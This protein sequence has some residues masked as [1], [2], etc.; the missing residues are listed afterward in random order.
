VAEAKH[1]TDL[2]LQELA[3][4]ERVEAELDAFIEKRAH[5]AED[6]ENVA[7]LWLKTEREHHEK[8]RKQNAQDWFEY[9]D[10]IIRSQEATLGFLVAYHKQERARFAH[11][12]GLPHFGQGGD[13]A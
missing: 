1:I 2:S 8:H 7:N 5:Q 4:T 10:N 13:E 3:E 9:H 11:I 12:L 6:A